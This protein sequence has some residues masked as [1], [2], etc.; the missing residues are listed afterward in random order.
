M[1]RKDIVAILYIL[2]VLV[3][4]S[5]MAILIMEAIIKYWGG[6]K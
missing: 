3:L 1:D 6:G 2:L 4:S 5:G